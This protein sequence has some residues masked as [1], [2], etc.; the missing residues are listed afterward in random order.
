M[1]FH[2]FLKLRRLFLFAAA[3]L[4]CQPAWAGNRVA[5]VI[6][7]SAYK[8]ATPLPNPVNDAGIVAA[9]LKNAGFD[10]VETRL[11]LQAAQI[12]ACCAISRMSRN[13]DVAVVYYAVMALNWKAQ[14]IFST[15]AP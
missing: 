10:V 5:L 12:G 14:T 2:G 9:T 6:G 7:N 11:D 15:D 4:I 3:L 13:A 8:N 1:N